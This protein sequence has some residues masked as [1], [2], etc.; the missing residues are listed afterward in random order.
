M[1]LRGER[2]RSLEAELISRRTEEM[3]GPWLQHLVRARLRLRLRLRV[4]V[5]LRLRLRVR[6]RVRVRVSQG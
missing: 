6:V 2:I 1:G 4:R 3:H 5:R